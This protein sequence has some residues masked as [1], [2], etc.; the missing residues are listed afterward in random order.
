[1][2]KKFPNFEIFPYTKFKKEN[3]IIGWKNVQE[4]ET[5][6]LFKKIILKNVFS[7]SKNLGEKKIFFRLLH[8]PVKK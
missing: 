4:N 8:L 1:M 2:T 5:Y 6:K 3:C 7:L